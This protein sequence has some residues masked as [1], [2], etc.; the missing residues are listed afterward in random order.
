MTCHRNLLN[1]LIRAVSAVAMRRFPWVAGV[2]VSLWLCWW[3][4]VWP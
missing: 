2:N 4:V 3:G 1:A